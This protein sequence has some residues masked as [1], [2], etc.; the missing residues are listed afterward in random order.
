MDR[1]IGVF[2]LALGLILGLYTFAPK[3]WP[4]IPPW[5]ALLG[6]GIA[7]LL[8][9][10]GIGL[11]AADLRPPSAPQKPE[12]HLTMSGGNVF[13]PDGWPDRTGIGLDAQVWNT[14]APSIVTSWSMKVTPNGAESVIAQLTKMPNVLSATGP[15]SSSRLLAANSLETMAKE[16]AV[17][18]TPVS[19]VLLFYVSLPHGIVRASDTSWELTAKD[20]YER[21]TRVTHL[22]GDWQQR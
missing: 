21:E 6:I 5:A 15:F 2:G 12:L 10:I 1:A 20:I 18:M 9:G 17:G 7:I 11:A 22:V 4:K 14:G 13:V 8:F 19:G 3:T 16:N